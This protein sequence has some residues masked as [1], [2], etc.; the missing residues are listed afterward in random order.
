MKGPGHACTRSHG[1]RQCRIHSQN[2]RALLTLDLAR[3]GSDSSSCHHG[4]GSSFGVSGFGL[5]PHEN[6]VRGP[7]GFSP[8]TLGRSSQYHVW[9]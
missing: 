1:W 8:R 3:S 7:G 9:Q 4:D 2:G 6:L 5:Q